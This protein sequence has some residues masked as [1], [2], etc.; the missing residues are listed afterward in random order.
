MASE[1]LK[2]FLSARDFLLEYRTDYA[3][4]YREF[5][6][7]QPTHFNWALD[8]FDA[9]AAGNQRPALWVLDEDGSEIRLSFSQMS[10]RSS[11][12]ANFLRAIGVQRGD[13][14]LVMLGNEAALWDIMLAVIKLAEGRETS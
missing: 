2:A 14:I 7:P 4:A 5:Q 8:Y 3:T 11:R 1:P 10:D 9:M 13:R 12:I 6:W